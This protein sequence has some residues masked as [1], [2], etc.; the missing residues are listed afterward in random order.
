M[1]RTTPPVAG[2]IGGARG[3][4]DPKPAGS[5][6][7]PRRADVGGGGGDGLHSSELGVSEVSVWLCTSTDA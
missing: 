3:P 5:G 6:G 7:R 2:A 4:A 1:R